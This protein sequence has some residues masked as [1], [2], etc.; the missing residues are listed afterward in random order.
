MS[1]GGGWEVKVEG[2]PHQTI[3]V[4]VML[5]EDKEESRESKYFRGATK[6]IALAI[7]LC[8]KLT[9][10]QKQ[11]WW[12]GSERGDTLRYSYNCTC[13]DHSQASVCAHGHGSVLVVSLQH[14]AASAGA[15]GGTKCHSMRLSTSQRNLNVWRLWESPL[16]QKV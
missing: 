10:L 14:A 2:G 16:H 13:S 9:I 11:S 15:G 7:K 3:V 12:W 4:T 6:Q 1:D 5:V 8:T